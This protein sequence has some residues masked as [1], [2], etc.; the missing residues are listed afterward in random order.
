VRLRN[1]LLHGSYREAVKTLVDMP[2]LTIVENVVSFGAPLGFE[3]PRF[4]TRLEEILMFFNEPR[5]GPTIVQALEGG[6]LLLAIR[7]NRYY[8]KLHNFDTPM[9]VVHHFPGRPKAADEK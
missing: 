6:H 4:E 9:M 2:Q 7:V 3:V 1:Q 8:E 5:L